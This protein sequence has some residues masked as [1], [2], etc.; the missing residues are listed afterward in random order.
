MAAQHVFDILRPDVHARWQH[1]QVPG[2]TDDP[3]VPLH[4]DGAEVAG[5]VP[6][7]VKHLGRPSGISPIASHRVW[8]AY[9]ELSPGAHANLDAANRPAGAPDWRA[10]VQLR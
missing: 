10:A 3:D 8:A 1:D 7:I 6:R 2:P 4:V 5:G 9:H